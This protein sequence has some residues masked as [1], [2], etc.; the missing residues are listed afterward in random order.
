MDARVWHRRGRAWSPQV[1]LLPV[2]ENASLATG[3]ALSAKAARHL[4]AQ[5]DPL[6]GLA[7]WPCDMTA[8]GTVVT[9]PRLVD[10]P[11]VAMSGSAIETARRVLVD[12]VPPQR[13]RWQRFATR[14][15][16]RRWWMK[17]NSHKIS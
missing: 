2:A 3:Y 8:L 16:W 4:L 17:R 9:S 1:K 6:A 12:Q 11:P 7:D 10:H 14:T 15:Y 5:T 13:E